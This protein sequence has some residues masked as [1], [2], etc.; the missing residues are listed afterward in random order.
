MTYE[1]NDLWRGHAAKCSFTEGFGRWSKLE[2]IL[3]SA[4]NKLWLKDRH[5]RRK[6]KE[7]GQTY[8]KADF[9]IKPTKSGF[10]WFLSF[11]TGAIT[12][13][14]SSGLPRGGTFSYKT[15]KVLG[16]PGRVSHP[17]NRLSKL[18]KQWALHVRGGEVEPGR[19]VLGDVSEKPQLWKGDELRSPVGASR[20][21]TLREPTK[22]TNL[23]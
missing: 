16:K 19:L 13:H 17:S 9:I 7:T 1:S 2:T 21:G 8:S 14:P 4:R 6:N 15:K 23:W 10:S 3:I 18:L 5:L 11:N 22:K 12:H 20:A